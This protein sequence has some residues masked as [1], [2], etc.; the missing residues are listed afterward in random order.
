M[1][2][3]Q[4]NSPAYFNSL[5]RSDAIW[6]QRSGS[7]LAQVMACSLMASRHYLKQRWLIIS[8]VEWYSSKGKFTRDTSAI[9]H[10]NWKIKYLKFHW[11]FPG[12]NE[13]THWPPWK[14]GSNFKHMIFKILIRKSSLDTFCEMAVMWMA[15]TSLMSSQHWFYSGNGL[16][17]PSRYQSQS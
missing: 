14:C 10:W 2:G 6:W 16:T 9:N 7:T 4:Y 1:N 12:A 5:G 13:L 17:A 11:N 15:Q 3:Y 8:K